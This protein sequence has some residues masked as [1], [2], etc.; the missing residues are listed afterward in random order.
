MVNEKSL[1]KIL[2]HGD[3]LEKICS[4]EFISGVLLFGSFLSILY[5]KRINPATLFATVL[6][7]YEIRELFIH[8]TG[9]SNTYQ[10]FLGLLKLY[11]N[12]VKSKNTKKLFNSSLKNVRKT[13]NNK[14]SKTN[15]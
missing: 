14:L 6:Q 11:P 15:I 7:N 3:P 10:S 4:K 8:T 9:S 2:F 1:Q 13:G 5:N 12:L